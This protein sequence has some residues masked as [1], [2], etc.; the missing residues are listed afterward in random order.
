MEGKTLQSNQ[1]SDAGL[2]RLGDNG[3]GLETLPGEKNT[4]YKQVQILP[5]PRSQSA[6][7]VVDGAQM[8]LFSG[9]SALTMQ[10]ALPT[11]QTISSQRLTAEEKIVIDGEES[12]SSRLAVA[13]T[14]SSG[15]VLITGGKE[16]EQ[17][18]FLVSG[19]AHKTWHRRA[20]MLTPR[21]G[22]A[23]VSFQLDGKETVM[24]A[25]GWDRLGRTLS[26]DLFSITMY[27]S[28]KGWCNLSR[29]IIIC[30]DII[31]NK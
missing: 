21:I 13:V 18:V 20:D 7:V 28:Q 15:D 9:Y 19:L 10:R 12:Y 17:Q 23:A 29:I 14:L 25:G 6:S 31:V 8:Y 4:L 26:S 3:N 16:R 30:C 5:S 11:L 24:V 2:L 1:A 27:N 22:H